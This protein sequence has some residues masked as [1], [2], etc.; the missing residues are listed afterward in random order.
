[1]EKEQNNINL[2]TLS[3][4]ID[5]LISENTKLKEQLKKA[6]KKIYKGEI[7]KIS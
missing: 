5:M 6:N 2:K 3:R 4:K 1:M 7:K